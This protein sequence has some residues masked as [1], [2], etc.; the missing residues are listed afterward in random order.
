MI[1][2]LLILAILVLASTASCSGGTGA[3]A[4]AS[5]QATASAS[6]AVSTQATASASAAVS[7]GSSTAQAA[8]AD[9]Q[10]LRSRVEDLLAV[11]PQTKTRQQFRQAWDAVVT[12]WNDLKA[13]MSTVM[14]TDR[15][16]LET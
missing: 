3:S 13:S 1:R 5:P 6:A 12:A 4:Q 8:C 9:L 16:R 10:A 7:P 2:Q 15:Q 14:T 11:D